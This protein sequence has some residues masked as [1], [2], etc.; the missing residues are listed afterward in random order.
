MMLLRC[1][2]APRRRCGRR[3]LQAVDL[4]RRLQHILI[5]P[6]QPGQGQGRKS[7]PGCSAR[8]RRS[9]CRPGSLGAGVV[10]R[11]DALHSGNQPCSGC[12]V[13]RSAPLAGPARW[14][15]GRAARGGRS[16]HG[17]RLAAACG[18][19]RDHD[20]SYEPDVA[21][22][23]LSRLRPPPLQP[24][25]RNRGAGAAC[26]RVPARDER[27]SATLA[28]YPGGGSSLA[29]MPVDTLAQQVGMTGVPGV[30]LD[31]VD[32]HVSRGR[33]AIA[34][35]PPRCRVVL[36][37]CVDHSSAP[38]DLGLPGGEGVGDRWGPGT[39]R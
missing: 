35:R 27:A 37:Q 19:H 23:V 14:P 7:Q 21:L 9:R 11:D 22:I 1:G 30:L 13:E 31:Q 38:S 39:A 3:P 2:S 17:L 36:L 20:F 10:Q 24:R 4:L 12:P 5:G 26:Y 6:R 28:C 25:W 8:R 33:V 29:G 15:T 32:Q 34:G 16:G 18:L